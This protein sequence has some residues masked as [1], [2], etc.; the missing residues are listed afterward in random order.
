MVQLLE[1]TGRESL[2][3]HQVGDQHLNFAILQLNADQTESEVLR[4]QAFLQS[5]FDGTLVGFEGNHGLCLATL[6]KLLVE[7]ALV[8]FGAHTKIPAGCLITDV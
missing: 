3:V 1:F 6:G 4:R 2:P 7:Q 5:L 8:D